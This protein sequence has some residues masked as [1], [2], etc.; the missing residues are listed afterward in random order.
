[1]ITFSI[2]NITYYFSS[3]TAS[4]YHLA[5][6]PTLPFLDFPFPFPQNPAFGIYPLKIRYSVSLPLRMHTSFFPVIFTVF[7][8]VRILLIPCSSRICEQPP[9]SAISASSTALP[10]E[11]SAPESV[12][13]VYS[14]ATYDSRTQPDAHKRIQ[15]F[16]ASALSVDQIS[17]LHRKGSK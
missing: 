17:S 11:I 6:V 13:S 10:P 8:C 15:I 9:P 7:I 4:S 2:Q 14:M 12:P 1:M 16:S 5:D 3:I